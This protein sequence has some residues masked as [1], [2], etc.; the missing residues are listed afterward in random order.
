MSDVRIERVEPCEHDSHIHACESRTV[1]T[2]FPPEVRKAIRRN[3]LKGRSLDTALAAG[4]KVMTG[5]LS[6]DKTTTKGEWRCVGEGKRCDWHSF[7]WSDETHDRC[8]WLGDH[9]RGAIR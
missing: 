1:L 5:E 7:L 9:D 6:I 4:W 8:G 3:L 2:G